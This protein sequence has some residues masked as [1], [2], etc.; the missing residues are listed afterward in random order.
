MKGCTAELAFKYAVYRINKDRTLLPQSTLVYDIQYVPKKDSFRITKKACNQLES[1]VLALFGPQ[2]QNLGSTIQGLCEAMDVPHMEA[3]PD[4]L[5]PREFSINLHPSQ[6]LLDK[7]FGDFMTYL[8]WSRVAVLYEDM[9]SGITNKYLQIFI[10]SLYLHISDS[11]RFQALTRL[12]VEVYI[13]R[14]EGPSSYRPILS[15]VKAK[16]ITNIIIDTNAETIQKLFRA[17]SH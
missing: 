8:N 2:D 6:K 16:K 7:A 5:E 3:S 1:G 4:H 15:E 11:F 9:G 10:V 17:V 13:R 14:C 12:G